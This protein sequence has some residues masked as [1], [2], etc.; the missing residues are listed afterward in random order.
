MQCTHKTNLEPKQSSDRLSSWPFNTNKDED[1]RQSN[2][3]PWS[4]LTDSG[5]EQEIV[6][7]QFECKLAKIYRSTIPTGRT[8]MSNIETTKL[9]TP[10]ACI[11]ACCDRGPESC[12][13]AWMFA[14]KCFLIG[15]DEEK[16]NLCEP[17]QFDKP[18]IESTYYK[19]QLTTGMQVIFNYVTVLVCFLMRNYTCR[20]LKFSS[21][22]EMQWLLEVCE[23]KAPQVLMP[24]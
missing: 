7:A 24:R 22:F 6:N 23:I 14:K 19:V 15:C 9:T 1:S 17:L 20:C 3:N 10:E 12:Q 11:Q 5:N 16:E 2:G 8:L 18:G 13:Y 21:V 4:L